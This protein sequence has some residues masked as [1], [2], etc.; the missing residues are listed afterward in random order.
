MLNKNPSERPNISDIL[1]YPPVAKYV[2]AVKNDPRYAEIYN[3]AVFHQTEEAM[4]PTKGF[5]TK[6]NEERELQINLHE[7]ETLRL[8][9]FFKNID[10]KKTD[11]PQIN[12][13]YE[14][15]YQGMK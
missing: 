1:E 4:S 8:G 9:Q 14:N 3:E 6:L 11:L 13:G 7:K 5:S 12:F 10:L 15:F 2:T